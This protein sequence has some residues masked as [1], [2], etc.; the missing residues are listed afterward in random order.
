[1]LDRPSICPNLHRLNDTAMRHLMVSTAE[2]LQIVDANEKELGA[3]AFVF[4]PMVH[5]F[6]EVDA[7][8]A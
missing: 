4:D 6:G 2:R 5:H 3:V 8:F 7:T 1:M